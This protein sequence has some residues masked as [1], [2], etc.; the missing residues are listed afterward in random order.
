V[1][2]GLAAR[3]FVALTRVD[4][5]LRAGG[6]MTMT[7]LLSTQRYPELA[8][9]RGF[10][11]EAVRRVEAQPWVE[12]A[13]ITTF[14]PMGGN[15]WENGIAIEGR[16]Q[17]GAADVAVAGVRAV[18]P[19]YFRAIGATMRAGRGPTAADAAG[20]PPV[21]VVNEDLVRRYWPGARPADVLGRRIKLGD[22]ADQT[23]PWLT[24]VG[25]AADVKHAGLASET[26]PEL[27]V[28]FAQYPE[29]ALRVAG[30]GMAFVVRSAADPATVVRGVRQEVAALDPTLPLSNVRPLDEL[31]AD[32]VAEPRFRTVLLAAFALL[33]VALA[34]VGVYGV[35]SY[36]VAQR[37]RELGV[38]MALGAGRGQLLR[39]VLG[40]GLGLAAW[41]VAA[42]V[43]A[44]LA[45]T[46]AMRGLLYATSPT[47]PLTFA[48]VS[49][50]VLAVAA[51]AAYLPAR[52]AA[53]VDPMV[54]L[55]AE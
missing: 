1:G 30:R 41:G 53:R 48:A 36:A 29:W 42:G 2:A 49:L 17:R 33:A 26:R 21:V 19:G 51:A 54:A 22:A 40:E 35:I 55:R 39:L 13:A 6:V 18:S 32:S 27:Y 28:P 34:A 25:V 12:A 5:G 9:V 45:A 47:D 38:R 50:L 46:R 43:L 10:Y 14:L 11:D 8:R 23:E 52:R 31:V 15:N 24:V 3:S 7:T 44:A 4:P 37:T 16:E 20:A